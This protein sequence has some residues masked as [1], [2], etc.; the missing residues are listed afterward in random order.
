M[1]SG[2]NRPIA[3]PYVKGKGRERRSALGWADK[4]GLSHLEVV[5]LVNIPM[6]REEV[7]HDDE[8]D[9]AAARELDTVKAVEAREEGVRV[10]FDVLVIFLEDAPQEL[11]LRVS[12]RLD[13][14]AVVARE[15]EK[16]ARL[17]RRAQLGEDVLGGKGD[18]VVGGVEVEVLAQLAEDPRS[19]VL[20]LEVVLG[21]RRELV[22]DAVERRE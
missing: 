18:E 10:L 9:L 3:D 8:V 14:E 6:G 5:S 4:Q 20:E 16:G 13:D 19:V 1:S 12:D 2:Y 17:A 15:V 21:R 11:V 22:A 7:V